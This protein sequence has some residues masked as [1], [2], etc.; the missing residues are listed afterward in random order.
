MIRLRLSVNNEGDYG[1]GLLDARGEQESV[2]TSVSTAAVTPI[3]VA[4]CD[5]FRGLIAYKATNV[6]DGECVIVQ[7]AAN[8]VAI[9]H[10]YFQNLIPVSSS[11]VLVAH[12]HSGVLSWSADLV[13]VI[14][15]CGFCCCFFGLKILPG[16]SKSF[17]NICNGGITQYDRSQHEF[18]PVQI[19]PRYE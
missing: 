9:A 11:C 17:E 4:P 18:A 14:F 10:P 5:L 7:R 13:F 16:G 6:P 8:E 19:A 2:S 3:V 15:F 1:S 12:H